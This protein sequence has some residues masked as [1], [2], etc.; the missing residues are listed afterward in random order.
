MRATLQTM[1]AYIADSPQRA[2][3]SAGSCLR[4]RSPS[5]QILCCKALSLLVTHILPG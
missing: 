2:S 5:C 1:Q 3:R 4:Q